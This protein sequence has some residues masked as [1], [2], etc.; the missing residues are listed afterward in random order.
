M[1]KTLIEIYCALNKE[2]NDNPNNAGY[3]DGLT[4]AQ[5]YI[6]NKIALIKLEE[7][8]NGETDD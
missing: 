4:F 3:V 8:Q 1:E 5:H 7:I 2:A 6:A